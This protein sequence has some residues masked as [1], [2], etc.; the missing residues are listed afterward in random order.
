[1]KKVKLLIMSDIHFEKFNGTL[2]KQFIFDFFSKKI[3]QAKN[4][5]LEPVIVF[6]GDI[7]NQDKSYQWM[8]KFDCNIIYIAGNHEFWEGDYYETLDILQRN[9]P[10]NVKFLHNDVCEVG[11]YLI[12]GSTLWTDIGE[13][14]NPDLFINASTRMNDM[15]SITA[16][17]WYDNPENI[18]KLK[19]TFPEK[20]VQKTLSHKFWNGLIEREENKTAW[21]FISEVSDVLEVLNHSQNISTKNFLNNDI[22]DSISASTEFSNPNLTYQGLVNNLIHVDPKYSLPPESFNRLSKNITPS[23]ERLFQKIR[24]YQNIHK[25]EIVML[26]HHLPFYEEVYIGQHRL[27]GEKT[28]D[29]INT[30]HHQNFFVREGTDYPEENLLYRAIN[31]EVSR[32]N[33][34]AHI[35]NYYNN[36]AVNMPVY[37]MGLVNIWIHGHEHLFNY[38]DFLKGFQVI[39]NT[40]GV[41]FQRLSLDDSL[42]PFLNKNYMQYHNIKVSTAQKSVENFKESL[43]RTPIDSPNEEDKFA[44]VHMWLMKHFSWHDYEKSL[45]RM[46]NSCANI[47]NSSVEFSTLEFSNLSLEDKSSKTADLEELTNQYID[48]FNQ[49]LIKHNEILN[50]YALSVRVRL[51]REF[52]I[53]KYFNSIYIDN[54]K[55]YTHLLGA[56]PELLKISDFMGMFTGNMAFKNME[57]LSIMKQQMSNIKGFIDDIETFE[58]SDISFEHIKAFKSISNIS[59]NNDEAIQKTQITVDRKWLQFLNS[60]TSSKSTPESPILEDSDIL[61]SNQDKNDDLLEDF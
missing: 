45:D 15:T 38:S 55:Y 30:I 19:A 20:D 10:S 21:N 5:G 18:E 25:K 4:E 44:L 29:T 24:Q 33:D 9:A 53:Q 27:K 47:I 28:K 13:K 59:S 50:Q 48:I 57:Y 36:G 17:K 56:V 35:V 23:K 54:S 49:N 16:K 46:I 14:L 32:K 40:A 58:P 37:L 26:T 6:A 11:Q 7:D 3:T 60:L 61:P 22:I 34:I 8:S 1:M 42:H 2:Q 12:I 52:S 31:G 51:D 41:I 39:S 43:I